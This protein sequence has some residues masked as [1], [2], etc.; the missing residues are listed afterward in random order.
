MLNY[1]TPPLSC[2]GLITL[3]NI[4]EICPLAIPNQSSFISMHVPS[5]VKIPWHLLKLSSG[6]ENMGVSRAHNYVKIC[7]NCSLAVPK[8][9]STTS[10]H[11]PSLVKIHWRLLKLSS[12]NE[13]MD[14]SR[15]DNSVKI[16]WNLAI[17]NHKPGLYNISD[18][19]NLVKIHWCLLKLS[20][21]NE[22]RTDGP[23]KWGLCDGYFKWRFSKFLYTWLFKCS[24]EMVVMW[25]CPN[26]KWPIN[27]DYKFRHNKSSA[28]ILLFK[29]KIT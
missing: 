6:N 14:V 21:V 25:H 7:W 23:T 18:I 22:I 20:S 28:L 8:L 19:P 12:R 24:N 29:S 26:L 4:V 13:T 27:T 1:N 3:S 10:M 16:W 2:R 9:I 17:S 15:V 5:F 11:I